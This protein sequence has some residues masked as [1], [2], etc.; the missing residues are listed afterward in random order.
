MQITI[1][2]LHQVNIALKLLYNTMHYLGKIPVIN[3]II[4]LNTEVIEIRYYNKKMRF[5]FF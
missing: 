3:K 5:N 1:V 2:F 4:T